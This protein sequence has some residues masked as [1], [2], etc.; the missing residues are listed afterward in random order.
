MLDNLTHSL[1]VDT[2]LYAAFSLQP[3]GTLVPFPMLKLL[4]FRDLQ[5]EVDK[6]NP[7]VA[8]QAASGAG[9]AA[10]SSHD[11]VQSKMFVMQGIIRA[12]MQFFGMF[13]S[14]VQGNVWQNEG[15]MER[16]FRSVLL[17]WKAACD[18]EA[19]GI[20]DVVVSFAIALG[21]LSAKGIANADALRCWTL[22]EPDGET[23]RSHIEFALTNQNGTPG[24]DLDALLG[25]V[26]QPEAGGALRT[27]DTLLGPPTGGQL[28]AA[29]AAAAVAGDAFA[30]S[31]I[32]G[33]ARLLKSF[34][35][36]SGNKSAVLRFAAFAI[37]F[38]LLLVATATVRLPSWVKARI[39]NALP[40]YDSREQN[41]EADA[42]VTTAKYL[43]EANL[44]A[45]RLTLNGISGARQYVSKL[46]SHFTT[47]G[48]FI[49]L[50]R[51]SGALMQLKAIQVDLKR[52]VN[53]RLKTALVSTSDVLNVNEVA[54]FFGFRWDDFASPS[55]LLGKI[56]E[57]N[58]FL[59]PSIISDAE[60]S[61]KIQEALTKLMERPEITSNMVA[62]SDTDRQKIAD[63]VLDV[64]SGAEY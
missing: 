25:I 33:R 15:Q 16:M 54:D 22:A 44:A 20:W 35:E 21:S 56:R 14:P 49:E 19:K 45:E 39:E 30:T 36:S 18:A 6:M 8:A 31:G 61:F 4:N 5:N 10:A 24:V 58:D 7:S 47:L 2:T 64:A 37:R 62:F 34:L 57:I 23:C 46:A 26:N 50:H 29:A 28:A 53:S 9:T 12:A 3:N 40:Q 42:A 27:I 55:A 32:L 60:L 1:G 17:P 48:E 63:H 59:D 43:S 13:S 52:L 41:P 51:L 38:A 11:A